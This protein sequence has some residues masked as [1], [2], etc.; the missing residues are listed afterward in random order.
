MF[1][2]R[3]FLESAL[4]VYVAFF[5][6]SFSL[7]P[8]ALCHLLRNV[9]RVTFSSRRSKSIRLWFVYCC[10]RCVRFATVL[11]L[12]G[13]LTVWVLVSICANDQVFHAKKQPFIGYSWGGRARCRHRSEVN[14]TE[15]MNTAD[16][17][18]PCVDG[19]DTPDELAMRQLAQ[20]MSTF[21]GELEGGYYKVSVPVP[22]E[23]GEQKNE[24]ETRP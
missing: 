12:F 8:S 15:T 3:Y 2:N 1:D 18:D 20:H 10:C 11:S 5:V 16:D 7:S 21:A 13:L 17:E 4:E 22:K 14:S 19:W 9:V 6:E 24:R 23:K